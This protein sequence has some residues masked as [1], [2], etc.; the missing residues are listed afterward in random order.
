MGVKKIII[1]Q[2]DDEI[3]FKYQNINSYRDVS[4]FLRLCNRDARLKLSKGI[5][6][7]SNSV[8]PTVERA[9]E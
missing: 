5:P 4:D 9:Q 2:K 1:E 8:S 3:S 6:L 7:D